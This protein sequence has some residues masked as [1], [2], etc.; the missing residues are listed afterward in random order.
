LSSAENVPYAVIRS[1]CQL[2][3]RVPVPRNLFAQQLQR[4]ELRR[5]EVSNDANGGAGA[6]GRSRRE[7]GE[8][9]GVAEN[10][11][12]NCAVAKMLVLVEASPPYV[13]RTSAQRIDRF[14]KTELGHL[15][16]VRAAA[17]VHP[18]VLF[19]PLRALKAWAAGQAEAGEAVKC[20]L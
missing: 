20:M 4:L 6:D 13:A 15:T 1:G 18:A 8:G 17:A 14:Y 5:G 2:S 9:G 7:K 19:A 3:G 16:R 11:M 12:R 10:E